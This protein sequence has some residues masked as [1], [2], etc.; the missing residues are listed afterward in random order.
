MFEPSVDSGLKI[1]CK[2]Q[3]RFEKVNKHAL[4][5]C[6]VMKCNLITEHL[7]IFMQNTVH[8]ILSFESIH[9]HGC[10]HRD[11]NIG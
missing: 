4:K 9:F 10:M 8:C 2:T 3:G 6:S 5:C 1:P 7:A 11:K